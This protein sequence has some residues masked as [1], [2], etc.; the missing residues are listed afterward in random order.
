MEKEEN[1]LGKIAPKHSVT[2]PNRFGVDMKSITYRERSE[3]EKEDIEKLEEDKGGF[4][5]KYSD[6]K[7]SLPELADWLKI[8]SRYGNVDSVSQ[9]FKDKKIPDRYFMYLFTDEHSYHISAYAP[10]NGNPRGYLGCIS[11]CRKTRVG[12]NWHRGSDLADGPYSKETF[13]RIIGDIVSF[14]LKTIQFL[15]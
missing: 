9:I 5:I 6:L 1:K 8:I 15:K 13:F 2:D 4:L 11:S 10:S 14:E 7:E 3:L 12:E